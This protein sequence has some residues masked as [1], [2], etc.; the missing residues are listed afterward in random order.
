[1][2]K[3]S[4]EKPVNTAMSCT[5]S[6][7]KSKNS[8]KKKP[9]KKSAGTPNKTPSIT[10]RKV[11]EYDINATRMVAPK[12]HIIK[13]KESSKKR[14]ASRFSRSNFQVSSA[15]DERAWMGVNES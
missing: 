13:T 4:T 5:I 9:L 15:K 10:A 6:R 7:L 2:V 14:S 12:T 1:M 8:S 11:N 3:I